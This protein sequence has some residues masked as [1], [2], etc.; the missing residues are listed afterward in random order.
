MR[1]LHPLMALTAEQLFKAGN[2]GPSFFGIEIVDPMADDGDQKA[3]ALAYIESDVLPGARAEV[4]VPFRLKTGHSNVREF[5]ETR[6]PQM[7]SS[8][9][10]SLIGE[11]EALYDAACKSYGRSELNKMV[12]SNAESYDK[13][14]DQDRIQGNQR[15]QKLLDWAASIP[16][17]AD[18]SDIHSGNE[19]NRVL[20]SVDVPATVVF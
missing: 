14:S 3:Q 10:E 4:S 5:I 8:S 6:Y 13:D 18:A 19:H 16:V 11:G 12:D 20:K 1:R 15:L 9:R 7:L 17:F 2:L